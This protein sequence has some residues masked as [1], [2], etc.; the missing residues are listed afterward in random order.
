MFLNR[1]TCFL[2]R[3]GLSWWQVIGIGLL[4]AGLSYGLHEWLE[5]VERWRVPLDKDEHFHSFSP[6]GRFTFGW[7]DLYKGP[8]RKRDTLTGAILTEMSPQDGAYET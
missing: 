4:V 2:R 6:D 1:S 3:F 7:V 8:F 5:P